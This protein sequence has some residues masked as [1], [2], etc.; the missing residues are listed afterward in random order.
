[1]YTCFCHY[2]TTSSSRI[3]E[4]K[5]RLH[6]FRTLTPDHT[7]YACGEFISQKRFSRHRCPQPSP[8]L[9][10]QIFIDSF[11]SIINTHLDFF[12]FSNIKQLIYK[13]DPI[14]K[15]QPLFWHTNLSLPKHYI[16]EIGR[17]Y[18]LNRR[19]AEFVVNP[20]TYLRLYKVI[21]TRY[22]YELLATEDISKHYKK[23]LH[24]KDIQYWIPEILCDMDDQEVL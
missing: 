15:D 2:Q 23:A 16:E 5:L 19:D 9:K 12:K 3:K 21:G 10:L 4:H 17:L 1:M 20:E 13:I 8:D 14:L 7:C 22:H 24:Q 11:N 6:S 18:E